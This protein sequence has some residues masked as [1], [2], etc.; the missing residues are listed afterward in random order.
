MLTNGANSTLYLFS[1]NKHLGADY[2]MPKLNLKHK[3]PTE[4][5]NIKKPIN[6]Y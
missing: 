5:L 4:F 6:Y 1:T 3:I 2:N